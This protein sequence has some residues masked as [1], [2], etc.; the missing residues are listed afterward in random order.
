MD[1]LF[2][3]LPFAQNNRVKILGTTGLKRSPASPDIP[4]IA[5]AGV[6]GF[7]AEGWMGFLAPKGT[8][9][10]IRERL[11]QEIAKVLRRPEVQA[12][13]LAQAA[14]PVGSAPAAFGL[15]LKKDVEKNVA[16][17]KQAGIKP[18]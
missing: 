5:E 8:P 14:E 7:E 2:T 16:L 17:V 15:Y 18:Q 6:P 12:A 3:I 10:A 13:Y 1:G 11:Q 4:T 9:L